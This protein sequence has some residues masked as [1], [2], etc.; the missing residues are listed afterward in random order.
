MAF[1][2]GNN[3]V[4]FEDI[5]RKVTDADLVSYYLGVTE[6]PCVICSPLRKD[7]KPSFGLYSRDG[8]RIYWTDLATKETG[9]IYDLLSLMWHCDYREVLK[10][11]QRDIK[12][13][14]SGATV[15]TYSPCAIRDIGS[16][17]RNSDLQCKIREWRKYDIDY[18][19]SYGVPL[20]WLKYADVYPISHKIVISEG[21]RYVFGADKLAYAF[22]ERKE[23]KITLK[24][25]Q[26]MNKQYKW[27]NK[28]DRSVISL[29]T[30]I[31]EKGDRVCICSSLK[32][33]LCLWANTGIPAIAVQGEGYG[34][35]D[36]AISELKRRFK[37]VYILFDN[38]T[39]GLV[40]GEKLA[41]QTGFINIV[42]PKFNGGKD[43]SDLFHAVGKEEFV[44]I[45]DSLFNPK[46]LYMM[47][48]YDEDDPFRL[49]F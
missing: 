41:N 37:K 17:Q 8:N 34:I 40:D 38:D 13:F 11:I 23:S 35:S 20:E 6:I 47:E 44:K 10:R 21:K 26:P 5:K 24:I 14:T 42:L 25:Y 28:H 27:A 3:S 2:T 31:P 48:E 22:V 12:N 9:G 7:T 15:G 16:Y 46:P 49:P 30:K 1:G 18:W 19:A 43:V 32:D 36:T 4:S 29:W 33:A 45:I 39:A